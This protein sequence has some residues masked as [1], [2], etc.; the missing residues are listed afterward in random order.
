MI[1][2]KVRPVV[3]FKEMNDHVMCHTGG[4][5]TNICEEMLRLWRQTAEEAVIVDLE[6]AYLQLHESNKHWQYQLVR[7]KVQKYWLTRL[8]LELNSGPEVM[9]TLLKTILERWIG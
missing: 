7:N 6:L 2:G 4:E 3:D 8:G 9:A 1:K 5:A